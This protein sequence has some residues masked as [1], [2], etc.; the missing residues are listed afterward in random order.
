MKKNKTIAAFFD[1]DGTVYNGVVAFDFLIFL[2]RNN[3]F[4]LNDIMELPALVCYYLMDKFNLIERYELNKRLYQKIKGQDSGLL[5]SMSKEFF[6]QNVG[7]KLFPVMVNITQTHKKNGRKVVI[8]TSAL[9]E[10]VNPVRKW[11][12]IDD[13]IAT[14]VKVNKGI[15][16]GI[17]K[18]LPVGKNRVQIIKKYCRDRNI[19]IKKSYAY[20]DHY[21]DMP[22][23]ENI[24]NPVAVNPDRKLRM[25]ARK[26]NWKIIDL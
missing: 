12:K 9:R 22:L 4:G 8:V 20:S 11:V 5:E 23:L 6:K 10:I 3:K 14:E 26:K 2:V 21:S 13:I 18:R 16:T 7:K 15:Y 1:F 19:D 25:N 24:G 17:I